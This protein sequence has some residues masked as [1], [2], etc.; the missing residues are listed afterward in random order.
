MCLLGGFQ[1]RDGLTKLS[2]RILGPCALVQGALKSILCRTPQE[3]YHNTLSFLKVRAA[4]G[5]PLWESGNASSAVLSHYGF[6]LASKPEGGIIVNIHPYISLTSGNPYC[7]WPKAVSGQSFF[8]LLTPYASRANLSS[9]PLMWAVFF[10]DPVFLQ[11]KFS[12]LLSLSLFIVQCGSLLWGI[13]CHPRTPAHSPFW[14]HVPH[15][16]YVVAGTWWQ[17]KEASLQGSKDNQMGP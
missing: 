7:S 3:F 4:C 1:I 6:L 2:Q 12:S 5:L 10:N 14:G 16:E 17:V 15:G 13:G 8:L 9:L 11:L